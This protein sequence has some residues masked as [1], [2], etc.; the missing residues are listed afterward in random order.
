MKHIITDERLQQR[1]LVGNK[2]AQQKLMAERGIPVPPFFCLSAE[3]YDEVFAPLRRPVSDVLARVDFNQEASLREACDDIQSRFAA[4]DLSPALRAAILSAFDSHFGASGVVSVRSSTLGGRA[5]ESEDSLENPFAGMADS[6]LYIR[7]GAILD[8]IRRCWAS[9]FTSRS[10]LY[11]R[12]HGID[13]CS[14]SIAVGIQQM[15]GGERSFVMFTCEPNTGAPNTLVAAGYGIG[16]GVVQEKVAVDHYFVCPRDGVYRREVA[17]K[18]ERLGSD[19]LADGHLVPSSVPIELQDAPCLS[20]GELTELTALGQKIEGLFGHPQDI[21]GTFSSDGR[22]H[23]LQSR[24][25][26]IDV[27]GRSIWSNANITESFPGTSTALTYSF[28]RVFYRIIFYDLY[29]RFGVSADA[30]NDH[31]DQLDR[32][33]GYIGGRLYYCVSNWYTLHGLIA[34]FPLFREP[35]EK[36]MGLPAQPSFGRA[37]RGAPLALLQMCRFAP[38]LL[39]LAGQF[40]AHDRNMREFGSWWTGLITPLRGALPEDEL[41]IVNT[42]QSVLREVGNHWGVTLINDAFLILVS[43]AAASCLVRWV[44]AAPPGLH[45]DLLCG[46][47]ENVSVSVM[48]SAVRFAERAS[49]CPSLL[50]ALESRSARE[51]W[52]ALERGEFEAG[53]RDA[54]REHVSR[55]GDRGLRELELAQPSLRD[56]PWVL[57][58]MT[59]EY[60]RSG[61]SAVG[62]QTNEEK[63]RA[64]AEARLQNLLQVRWRRVI[65]RQLLAAQRRLILHRENSRYMRSELFGFV[66]RSFRKLG[67]KLAARGVLARPEDVVQLTQHEVIGYIDGTGVNE[68]LRALAEL[69]RDE[70]VELERSEPPMYFTSQ[71]QVRDWATTKTSTARDEGAVLRGLGSSS[72]TVR[73]RACVVRDPVASPPPAAGMILVARETDPGWLFLMLASKGIVVERGT[74]LSHTAITGRKLGIPTVVA[75]PDAMR[76]IPDGALIEIDGATGVVRI[77]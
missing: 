26:A 13:P 62:L 5:E 51:V 25:I 34:L 24:P 32:M 70:L 10:V 57:L 38:A 50:A 59:R 65:L 3:L 41:A 72:G 17:L 55:Y 7:R 11:R 54:F 61:V 39:R 28:A 40:A 60:V 77:L 16:A 12:W 71:G 18:T 19:G 21:E 48:L 74:M 37:R 58:E 44:P 14:F 76:R 33:V 2:F 63:V 73:A 43:K 45:S 6:F 53:L 68:N 8:K 42:L 30:L 69:R 49:E 67:E 64:C 35:W 66:K 22:V 46:G 75:V 52:A 31:H 56:T 36:M 9:G 27:R 15:V 4:I 20:D 47:E 1:A 29:R 23:V